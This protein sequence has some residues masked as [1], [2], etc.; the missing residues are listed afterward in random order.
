MGFSQ[1]LPGAKMELR[2]T[3]YVDIDD[4]T[5]F[6]L[7]VS[8][9]RA[10]SLVAPSEALIGVTFYDLFSNFNHG[11]RFFR[12]DDGTMAGVFMWGYESPNFADRGTGYNYYNGTEWAPPPEGIIETKKTGWPSIAPFGSDGEI[13]ST[14]NVAGVTFSKRDTKGTGAWTEFDFFG[15]AGIEE[16]ITWPRMVTTG[17]NNE[18]IHM[19]VNT[20]GPWEDQLTTI[21]YSRSNDGGATWDPE[22]IVLDGMGADYYTQI[23]QDTYVMASRGNT[24]CI[25][26]SDSDRDLFYMRSDDNGDT[27]EKVIVWQHP[28]PFF[29]EN[30]P[31][32]PFYCTDNS[33]QL[34]ID[35]EGHV[36]VVF[37]I[38]Q[39]SDGTGWLVGFYNDG[40]GYWN[41]M[42]E[43]FS[44]DKEALAPPKLGLA[45]SEMIEDVN[46]IGWMQDL[47]GDGDTNYVGTM[48]YNVFG[49][50]THP[51]ITVDEYGQRF[52]IFGSCNEER[53]TVNPDGEPINYRDLY[54]RAYANGS[55]GEFMHLQEDF[56]HLLDEC[57][58]PMLASSSDDNIHYIYNADYTPGLAQWGDHAYQEQRWIYGMLPKSELIGINEN[59]VIDNSHVSQN[60]PNPF[61]G[62]SNVSIKLEEAATL[63]LVVTNMTGQKVMEIN[64]GQ[65]PAQ[66]HI[67]TIDASNLN[68]GIYFYTVTA[69]ASQVTKKMI[70]K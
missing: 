9:V 11:Q 48:T 10:T 44:D 6:D 25:L 38:A 69:D 28:Y 66:T 45:N 16:D 49:L 29:D 35:Y 56:A 23:L 5:K 8:T 37:G 22:N 21:V 19:V 12:Y 67:F 39:K 42:M 46:C 30:E 51:T 32:D 59:E 27:W 40:I 1:D 31:H 52:V 24:V 18:Y 3:Q 70:V 63:S 64:K 2:N 68:S 65:V 61:S 4:A 17:D 20:Y 15:P 43:P 53:Q 41:D 50:S 14:H 7:P 57:I 58:W 26:V 55:W 60:F 34:T 36:H 47:N 33:A 13:I 62:I 54:A